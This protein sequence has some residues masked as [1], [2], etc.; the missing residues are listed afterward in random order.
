VIRQERHEA[1]AH[2]AGG[3]DDPDRKLLTHCAA[4]L[5]FEVRTLYRACAPESRGAMV[6]EMP[7]EGKM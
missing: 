2:H 5:P 4:F 1:L 7:K 3:A 6:A